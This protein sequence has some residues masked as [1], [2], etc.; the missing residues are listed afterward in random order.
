MVDDRRDAV[1]GGDFQE[2]R[3]ELLA[4]ADV[5][6]MYLVGQAGLF[7]EQRDFMAVGGGLVIQVDHGGLQMRQRGEW[8]TN[9]GR[10]SSSFARRLACGKR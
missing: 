1:V 9:D 4:L 6:R 10:R 3:L 7:E 8:T 2:I 5:D